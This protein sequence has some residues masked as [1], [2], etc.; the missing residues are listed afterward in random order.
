MKIKEKEREGDK[1]GR[2]KSGRKGRTEMEG[3]IR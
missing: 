1:M 2:K 3:T